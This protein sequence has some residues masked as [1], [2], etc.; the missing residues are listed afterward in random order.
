MLLAFTC[1][2]R[3]RIPLPSASNHDA[4]QIN[5]PQ[6]FIWVLDAGKYDMGVVKMEDA[7]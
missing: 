5:A 4:C 3:P 2:M 1:R 6:R 7:S